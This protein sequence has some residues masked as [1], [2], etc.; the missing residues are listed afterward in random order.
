MKN[1]KI[2]EKLENEKKWCNCQK[3]SFDVLLWCVVMSS[4]KHFFYIC[5]SLFWEN[6]LNISLFERENKHGILCIYF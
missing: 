1:M 3:L 6:L 4:C 2:I 5:D